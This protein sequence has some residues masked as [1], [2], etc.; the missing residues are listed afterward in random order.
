MKRRTF[1]QAGLG[2]AAA[3][4]TMRAGAAPERPVRVLC[5]AEGT[6]PTA[7]YPN[8]ISGAVADALKAGD[9]FA[10]KTASL[11]D[12]DQG[13]SNAAL[14]GTDVLFWWGHIRHRRVRDDRVEAILKRVREGG[15]GFVALHSA[16]YSKPFKRIDRG[17]GRPGRCGHQ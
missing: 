11:T 5:W 15:M 3:G 16:H 17:L 9:G 8:D 1:L 13:L 12:E 4:L 14:A 6:A 10:V 7:V 2:A